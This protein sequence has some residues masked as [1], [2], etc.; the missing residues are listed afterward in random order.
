MIQF[1]VLGENKYINEKSI[2]LNEIIKKDPGY[3][4][5]KLE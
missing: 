2:F 5:S 3:S 4:Y 1:Q